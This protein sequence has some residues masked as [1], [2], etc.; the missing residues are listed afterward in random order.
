LPRIARSPIEICP[1]HKP[2]QWREVAALENV[3]PSPIARHRA[4]DDRPDAGHR[5]QPL[6]TGISMSTRPVRLAIMPRTTASANLKEA[7]CHRLSFLAMALGAAES[8]ADA[9]FR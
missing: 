8:A 6:A 3:S 9:S 1:G 4:G 5:H 2:Q 7:V